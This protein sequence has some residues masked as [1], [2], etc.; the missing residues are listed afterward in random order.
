VP[1]WLNRAV[2]DNGATNSKALTQVRLIDPSE[3]VEMLTYSGH[4][5][6]IVSDGGHG[7]RMIRFT[8]ETGV[9]RYVAMSC[10]RA[11]EEAKVAGVAAKI[12]Y[13]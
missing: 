8:V 1:Q 13:E 12:P 3:E 11:L 10:S 6:Y 9:N 5:F 4:T 2:A 7:L